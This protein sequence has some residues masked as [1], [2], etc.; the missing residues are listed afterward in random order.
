MTPP[1]ILCASQLRSAVSQ[2]FPHL[3]LPNLDI[4]TPTTVVFPP[5][6]TGSATTSATLNADPILLEIRAISGSRMFSNLRCRLGANTNPAPATEG[7]SRL[8]RSSSNR[9]HLLIGPNMRGC[10]TL[11]LQIERDSGS[12]KGVDL[13][14]PP[15]AG[16]GQDLLKESIS[17]PTCIWEGVAR[18]WNND[19]ADY[20]SGKEA[21]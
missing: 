5:R 7:A 9:Q 21:I 13:L 6:K 15:R 8:L 4:S 16:V 20:W 12:V 17:F 2:W 10:S 18:A 19:K 14:L 3:G 11:W 1:H